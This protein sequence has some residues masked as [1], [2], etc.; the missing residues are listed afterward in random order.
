M[1]LC[2]LL[3]IILFKFIRQSCKLLKLLIRKD[4]EHIEQK[5]SVNKESAKHDTF[6]IE[7]AHTLFASFIAAWENI[8]EP[9]SLVTSSRYDCATIRAHRQI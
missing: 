6:H 1:S 7:H 9:E 8:P 2:V 3:I 4:V 5:Y